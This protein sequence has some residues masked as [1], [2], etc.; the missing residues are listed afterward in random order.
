MRLRTSRPAPL[1][2]VLAT[3]LALAAGT[4]CGGETGAELP[5]R[6]P[7]GPTTTAPSVGDAPPKPVEK[8]T[9]LTRAQVLAYVKGGVG[10]FLYDGRVQ[11]EDAPIMRNGKFHGRKLIAF[12]PDWDV[13]LLP[14]DVVV[15]VNGNTLA[16]DTDAFDAMEAAAKAKAIKIE[17]ERSG[18]PQTI[19]LP[20][21]D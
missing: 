21:V 3:A 1:A 19:E 8:V 4:G 9:K 15:K 5:P 14:G 7:A 16:L 18:A 2:H 10:R 13:G 17:I 11:F 6:A 12:R 20:I